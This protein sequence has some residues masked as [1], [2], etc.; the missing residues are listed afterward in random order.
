MDEGFM[1]ESP[2]VNRARVGAARPPR[3]S[4]DYCESPS[5][6]YV[7]KVLEHKAFWRLFGFYQSFKGC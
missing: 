4:Q 1:G 6:G 7:S 5:R 2:R 3:N